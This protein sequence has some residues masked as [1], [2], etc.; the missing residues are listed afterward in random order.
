M[1]SDNTAVVRRR[2][3]ISSTADYR[4]SEII[5]VY[6]VKCFEYRLAHRIQVA[7]IVLMNACCGPTTIPSVEA[8]LDSSTRKRNG[9]LTR[10]DQSHVRYHFIRREPVLVN[11][12]RCELRDMNQSASTRYSSVRR[13][14]TSDPVKQKEDPI[15]GRQ[16]SKFKY[17][18]K[19]PV[20]PSPALQCTATFPPSEIARSASLMNSLT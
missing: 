20:R 7:N 16:P 3:F 6:S 10:S 8:S 14:L 4:G 2:Q 1:L 5:S 13:V 17:T 11:E 19:T 18:Y 12:I 9:R 15:S